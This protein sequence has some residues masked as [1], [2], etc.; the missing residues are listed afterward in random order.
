MISRGPWAKCTAD[1]AQVCDDLPLNVPTSDCRPTK[2]RTIRGTSVVYSS[3]SFVRWK[4]FD[5]RVWQ[6]Q[7]ERAYYQNLSSGLGTSPS[8]AASFG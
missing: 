3:Y 2:E 6:R 1:M 4:R 7:A 8:R 5:K